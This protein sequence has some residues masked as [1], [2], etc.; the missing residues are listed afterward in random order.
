MKRSTTAALIASS[1]LFANTLAFA[2]EG[3]VSEATAVPE[4]TR[5]AS[6][7]RSPV[8]PEQALAGSATTAKQA[9]RHA[10]AKASASAQ[11]PARGAVTKSARADLFYIYDARSTLRRDRDGDGYHSEFRI[12]FDADVRVGSALVYA[13]LYLRRL[14][15]R[16]WFLYHETDDFWI[17]GQSGSDEYFVTTTLDAGFPTAEYDVLIDL[18]EVGVPGIVATLGPLDTGELGFLPLEEVGLDVPIEMPGFSIG[19]V[20]T[21][22]IVDED[23]DGFYSRFRI[24]FDPDADFENRWAYARIWVRPRGGDWIEEFVSEDWLVETSGTRD[25][26]VL[27]IEWISG[28]P[29]SYYDVQIDLFDSAT[30]ALIASAGS[31]RPELAQ[32]PLEDRSRDRAPSAPTPGGG[33]ASHSR[34]GGGGAFGFWAVI[35]LAGLA[36]VRARR[37]GRLR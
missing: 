19:E 32:L 28:Y 8:D 22:L 24:T 16:D 27:D 21:D 4:P 34:E 3:K 13:R 15:E 1:F 14:G 10:F 12:R 18:Y 25:A 11:K 7:S 6:Y 2:A 17:Y 29:T 33:G 9:K 30:D 35:G 20:Y 5:S 36:A 23:R 37:L 26:Y 31:E